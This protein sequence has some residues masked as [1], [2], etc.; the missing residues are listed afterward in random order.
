MPDPDFLRQS[1]LNFAE[2][3]PQLPFRAI[4]GKP[5]R[6]LVIHQS[7]GA[8][9][10][11]SECWFF[12]CL[13]QPQYILIPPNMSTFYSWFVTLSHLASGYTSGM[14]IRICLGYMRG[15]R[16][17]VQ[18]T[19][20]LAIPISPNTQTNLLIAIPA[21]SQHQEHQTHSV[22]RIYFQR[23]ELPPHWATTGCT[24]YSRWRWT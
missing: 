5:T 8:Y 1:V 23:R 3:D 22:I 2:R 18:R 4:I 15:T 12:I 9:G 14:G 24:N 6:N 21:H 17:R 19:R 10:R 16:T 7:S 20:T 13:L 11:I